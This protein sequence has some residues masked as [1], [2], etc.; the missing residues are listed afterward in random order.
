MYAHTH[1]S[2]PIALAHS[3]PSQGYSIQVTSFE[4]LLST[5]PRGQGDEGQTSSLSTGTPS[6]VG[7][8]DT[9]TSA[10]VGHFSHRAPPRDEL[11]WALPP[12][13]SVSACSPP[14]VGLRKQ[15]KGGA[16]DLQVRK[17]VAND[18]SIIRIKSQSKVQ[19]HIK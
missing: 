18:M 9:H 19:I 16:K 8:T 12:W 6:L 7:K 5:S 13:G 2:R 14:K 17:I 10:L 4:H 1:T 11:Q 15:L 3:F